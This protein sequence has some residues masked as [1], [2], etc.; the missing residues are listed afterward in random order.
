MCVGGEGSKGQGKGILLLPPSPTNTQSE[1][2]HPPNGAKAQEL[3]GTVS[4]PAGG[5]ILQHGS[6]VRLPELQS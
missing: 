3:P 6:C 4:H 2:Q 1:K 5:K